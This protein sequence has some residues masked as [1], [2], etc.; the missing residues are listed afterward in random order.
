[1]TT[2][3]HYRY[4]TPQ[5]IAALGKPVRQHEILPHLRGI[6]L[7]VIRRMP[8]RIHFVCGPI[9]TGGVGSVSGNMA[10]FKGV[11]E[12]LSRTEHLNLFSQ[13]PFEEGLFAYHRQW[14]RDRPGTYPEPILTE[15]YDELF[16]TGRFERF[17]FIHGYR[18]SHGARWEHEQCRP[19]RIGKRY[20]SR[21]LSR[22][23]IQA[24]AVH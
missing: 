4:W 24:C 21:A 15:F 10:V 19:R 14:Q 13:M 17:H 8:P 18:S 5:H 23:I 22:Q 7:E 2:D 11:I 12:H 16:A 20:L 1:M 9:S 3:I 6:A